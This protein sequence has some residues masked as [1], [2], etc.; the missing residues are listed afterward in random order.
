MYFRLCVIEHMYGTISSLSEPGKNVSLTP[1]P[2]GWH[3]Y[4]LLQ[5][6]D[7]K[8][9]EAI[10]CYR[11]A[12]KW[13]KVNYWLSL[14][15]LIINNTLINRDLPRSIFYQV[16]RRFFAES[17]YWL[18]TLIITARGEWGSWLSI[19]ARLTL[20]KWLSAAMHSRFRWTRNS[21]YKKIL[22]T[23]H[24]FVTLYV[25]N[26]AKNIFIYYS[27]HYFT[28]KKLNLLGLIILPSPSNTE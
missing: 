9:D 20:I 22:N 14:H 26:S 15:S 10:K 24:K 16:L 2:L 7:R 18:F 11:N 1:W 12:L 13:D 8:Y 23:E 17:G 21:K 3:A 28:L 19:W 4:G 25:I 27:V 6:A 5:R